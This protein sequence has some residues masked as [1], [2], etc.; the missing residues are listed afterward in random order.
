MHTALLFNPPGTRF[1][2]GE[3][4]CQAEVDASSAVAL[5]PP[6]DLAGMAAVLRNQD[7]R[8]YVRDYPAERADWTDY[9]QDLAAIQ[10][11]LAVMSVTT[12]T[13]TGDM[14][15]FDIAK[16][17]NPAMVTAAKGAHFYACDATALAAFSSLD[18][19]IRGEADTVIDR[20]AAAYRHHTPLTC[21]PGLWVRSA[22]GAFIRTPD[23]PFVDDLDRLP[24]PARDLLRNELYVRPDTGEPQTT[25]QVSRGCPSRCI[26]C[27]SPL[28]SGHRLRRRSPQ[29]IVDELEECV[30]RHHIRN[31]F[32]RADT[33]TMDRLWVRALCREILARDLSIQ[34]AANSKVN[35][36][37]EETLVWMKRAGCWLVAFGIESGNEAI[38]RRLKKGTTVA[39]ARQAVALCRQHGIRTYGFYMI[40]LPWDTEDTIQQT[41]NLACDLA[42]DFHE[43]HIAMPYEGTQLER[44]CREYGLIAQPPVGHTYFSNPAAG[45][46]ALSRK[47]VIRWRKKGLRRL[48]L[49]PRYVIKTLGRVRTPREAQN[50]F[51]YGARLLRNLLAP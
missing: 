44:L 23:A 14:R 1:L 36:L 10:P 25:V 8:V 46:L 32:F 47:D 19:A 40:G 7:M 33:F 30:T 45:T 43:I 35:T 11:D 16:R 39:Q 50:Y 2:R 12:A 38:Q 9:E 48:Y 13:L 26:F 20:V 28:I 41:L 4:R 49:S 5:R 21:V 15:A 18:V 6:I 3:D 31:F 27:L 51:K 17:R 37:D 22:G 29:N 42:C 24:F 34:W